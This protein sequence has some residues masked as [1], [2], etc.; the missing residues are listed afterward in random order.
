MPKMLHICKPG[1]ETFLGR[2]LE[3]L[4]H[5][6]PLRDAGFVISSGPSGHPAPELCFA[7]ATLLDPAE[8]E[9]SSVNALAGAIADFTVVAFKDFRV[10]KPWPFFFDTGPGE[11]LPGRARSVEAE[12]RKRLAAK[13]SRVARLAT[14]ELPQAM[15]EARGLYVFFTGF[16]RLHTAGRFVLWGQHRMRDDSLAP[17]RS[18]L[19]AEEAYGI[20]GLEPGSGELVVDLGAAPGGWTY[21]AARR[22]ARVIAVDNGPLKGGALN[23]PL[24]Q[25]LREDAF[26]YTPRAGGKADWLFCDMIENPYRVMELVQR[27]LAHGWCRR[28]VVNLKYGH[29]DPVA[30]IE[31]VRNPRTGLGRHCSTLRIRA[32][33]H[34]REEITVVGEVRVRGQESGIRSQAR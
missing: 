1:N 28:F 4:G 27:W 6:V 34:N 14:E 22:G 16:N 15:V 18:Y 26:A 11:G 30:L 3:L 20:F 19:K 32:L 10:S 7:S 9:A 23:N 25:H 2:E 5:T 8:I 24:V 12:W 13:I 29:V 31:K 21:S 17:S 33:H